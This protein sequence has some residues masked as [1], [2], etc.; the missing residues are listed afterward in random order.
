MKPLL[1]TAALLLLA[2]PALAQ[3]QTVELKD[4][5]YNCTLGT[6]YMGDIEL[7]DGQYRGPAWDGKF[8]GDYPYELTEG[9]TIN[10]DGPLGGLS[11][12]GNTVVA[13]VLGDVGGTVGFDITI[14]LENGNFSQVTC[15]PE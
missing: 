5:R 3:L 10:W 15:S 11:S 8:E 1:S 12:G 14:Q 2:T 9:G 6:Y 13:T 7:E 4:G